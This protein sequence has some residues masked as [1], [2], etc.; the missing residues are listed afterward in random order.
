MQKLQDASLPP[1]ELQLILAA[2]RKLR[3]GILGAS[4]TMHSPVF[5]QRVHVFNIRLAILAHSW[6]SYLPSLLYLLGTLQ[7]KQ[8]PLPR[9]ELSEMTTYLILDMAAR[10]GDL[11][12]AFELRHN[13][14]QRFGYASRY[15]DIVLSAIMN[16]D[17]VKFWRAWRKV[18]GYTRAIIQWHT[19]KT[20]KAALKAIGRT[21]LVCDLDWVLFSTSGGDMTWAELAEAENVGWARDGDKIII[22][23][24]K[25]KP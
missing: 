6:E 17:W 8:H 16:N 19:D 14:R 11:K 18:D 2:L 13:S 20:R 10:Q 9:S 12:S 21:Y 4:S 24:P 15:A 7:T 25:P 3:E 23:K 5:A 1:Q 22:R